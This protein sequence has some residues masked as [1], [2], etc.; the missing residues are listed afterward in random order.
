MT[1][2]A[3]D[4]EKEL[5]QYYRAETQEEFRRRVESVADLE[6]ALKFALQSSGASTPTNRRAS[7]GTPGGSPDAAEVKASSPAGSTCESCSAFEE[8]TE[9]MSTDK[10]PILLVF[11]RRAHTDKSMVTLKCAGRVNPLQFHIWLQNAAGCF[12]LLKGL[13]ECAPTF[14]NICESYYSSSA[15]IMLK[16]QSQTSQAAN[17]A[18]SDGLIGRMKGFLFIHGD[19]MKLSSERKLECAALTEESWK[20]IGRWKQAAVILPIPNCVS[21]YEEWSITSSTHEE[22]ES[23]CIAL[24]AGGAVQLGTLMEITTPTSDIDTVVLV[25]DVKRSVYM[26]RVQ[27]VLTEMEPFRSH[28]DD[29]SL[30]ADSLVPYIKCSYRGYPVDVQFAVM[31]GSVLKECHEA[32]QAEVAAEGSPVRT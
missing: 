6:R 21:L 7:P 24:E 30:L 11:G 9:S 14:D 17:L 28:C 26:K 1:F 32:I 16:T 8:S 15:A 18:D 5:H 31:P 29:F 22:K 10:D 12:T 20:V 19:D 3:T 23:P 2:D 4:V 25:S 27:K 13:R